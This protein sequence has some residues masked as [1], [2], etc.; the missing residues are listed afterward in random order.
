MKVLTSF[1]L[2]LALLLAT[3]GQENNLNRFN[4][5]PGN[6][7][8]HLAQRLKVLIEYHRNKQYD[9]LFEMLPKLTLSI[10]S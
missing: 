10:L 4:P 6:Q 9:K 8:A 1:T 7:R 5:V 2:L 3:Y